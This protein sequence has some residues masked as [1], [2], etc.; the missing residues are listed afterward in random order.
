MLVYLRSAMQYE[1]TFILPGELT[2]AKQKPLLEK[3]TK[4]IEKE[5]GKVLKE[6]KWGKKQ[7]AYPIKKQSQGTYYY[8]ELDL[9]PDIAGGINRT[10]ELDEGILRHLLIKRD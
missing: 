7:L 1:L 9:P 2:E 3:L 8:W 6:D 4:L 10:F 5:G